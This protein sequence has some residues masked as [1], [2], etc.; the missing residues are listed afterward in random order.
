MKKTK[1]GETRKRQGNKNL[2]LF[3]FKKKRVMDV[4]K[5]HKFHRCNQM[6]VECKIN[7]RR[8][9]GMKNAF[10]VIVLVRILG[11]RIDQNLKTCFHL[12]TFFVNKMTF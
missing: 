9:K 11:I 3:C 4:I 2:L 10:I 6:I 12:F 7:M 5:F 1:E 8:K